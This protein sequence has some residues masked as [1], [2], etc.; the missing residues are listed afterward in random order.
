[1]GNKLIL[2]PLPLAENTVDKVIPEQVKEAVLECDMYLVEEIRTAR[3]YLSSLRLGLTIEDLRF[4]TLDKKTKKEQILHFFTNP[5][6][7]TIGVYT[8]GFEINP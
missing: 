1:M 8:T 7:K 6:I 4:E 3:R 2:I 5:K